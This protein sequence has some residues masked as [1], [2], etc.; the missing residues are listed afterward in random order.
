MKNRFWVYGVLAVLPASA[1]IAGSSPSDPG[2]SEQVGRGATVY[3]E[4]C[5]S[6]HGARLEGQLGWRKQGPD[7]TYPAPPHDADGH[8]WHHSDKLLFRYVKLGGKEAFKDIPGFTS[9]MPGFRNLLTD[10]DIWDAL[11]FIKSHWP[12][13]AR[14][15][16]EAVTENDN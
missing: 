11:A 3:A 9:A 5:A 13:E 12:E 4:A 14:A 1:G 8:T 2:D 10:Q 6:C 7:G 16:Q 15:Y